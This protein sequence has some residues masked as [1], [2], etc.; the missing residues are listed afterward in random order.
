MDVLIITHDIAG[1]N[2][3]AAALARAGFV[4]GIETTSL[5]GQY[6]FPDAPQMLLVEPKNEAGPHWVMFRLLPKSHKSAKS[7]QLGGLDY[8][9]AGNVVKP[10]LIQ[11][12][13]EL[14]TETLL[15]AYA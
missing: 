6:K 12:V 2:V 11:E 3:L 8:I 5:Q 13:V 14:C 4:C 7:F 15:C 9:F 1:A 10:L